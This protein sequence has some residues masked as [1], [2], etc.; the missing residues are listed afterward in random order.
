M[1]VNKVKSAG[2]IICCFLVFERLNLGI[3][4]PPHIG[5]SEYNTV[6]SARVIIKSFINPVN[7]RLPE[8]LL[9]YVITTFENRVAYRIG[10]VK[11]GLKVELFCKIIIEV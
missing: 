6:G 10:K 1:I 2:K 3:Q 7:R 5:R 4:R 11:I 9:E 8:Y